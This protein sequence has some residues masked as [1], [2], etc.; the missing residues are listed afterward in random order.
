MK[1]TYEFTVVFPSPDD[2]QLVYGSV[3]LVNYFYEKKLMLAADYEHYLKLAEDKKLAVVVD[4]GSEVIGT[5]AFTQEYS[6]GIWEFGGWAVDESW[7]KVGIGLMLIK[8]LFTEN[9]HLKIITF[10]NANSSPILEKLGAEEIDDHSEIPEEAFLLCKECPNR[11]EVGC[12]DTI[13]N[14]AP[15]VLSFIAESVEFKLGE[16]IIEEYDFT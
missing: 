9:Q 2:E 13:Y 6:N 15:I 12:C 8:A 11:P 4:S 5:A 10:G 1:E 7:Q 14:L 3:E 16:E